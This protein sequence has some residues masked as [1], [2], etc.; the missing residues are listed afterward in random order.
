MGFR[1]T[2][3][4]TIN[5]P[6]EKRGKEL[7]TIDAAKIGFAG[8]VKN[9]SVYIYHPEVA[10]QIFSVKLML[11]VIVVTVS[12][13]LGTFLSRPVSKEVLYNFHHQWPPGGPGWARVLRDAKA[14]GVD[15]NGKEDIDW[16]M[17]LKLLCVFVGSVVIYGALFSIG[18]F[19][20]G[21]LPWG[22][23]LGVISLL[24]C[25]FLMKAF[26]QIKTD[27]P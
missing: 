19:V 26:T 9:G 17:P 18:S 1:E 12:W 7:K 14:E 4:E 27:S 13:L 21:N 23:S 11:M 20:Y 8:I 5:N 2:L 16:Q 3:L 24:G 15:L 6:L 25:F 22:I 10:G